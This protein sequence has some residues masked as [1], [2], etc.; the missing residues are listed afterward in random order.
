MDIPFIGSSSDRTTVA[1]NKA[2]TRA[3]LLEGGLPVPEGQNLVKGSSL[4]LDKIPELP[5]VV[6]PV[7]CEN[8]F[9]VTLVKSLDEMNQALSKAY[10]FSNEVVVDKFIE[11]RELRCSVMEKTLPNG[12]IEKI[13]LIPQEYIIDTSRVRSLEDK[14]KMDEDGLPLGK[15]ELGE[16]LW[17]EFDN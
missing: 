11:G 16:W 13:V 5:C 8:S 6:K 12:E 14:I 1:I 4:R 7:D 9:G 10:E 17:V 15:Y 3:I 2:T